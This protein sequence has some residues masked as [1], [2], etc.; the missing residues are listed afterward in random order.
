MKNYR[1][2]NTEQGYLND[3]PN[4]SNLDTYAALSKENNKIFIDQGMAKKAIIQPSKSGPADICLYDKQN[5]KLI[6]VKNDLFSVDYFPADKYAPIGIVVVPG[7]HNVYNDGSCG[8]M[9]LKEMNRNSPDDGSTS[10]QDMSWGGV[11]Y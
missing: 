8:V 1:I 3:K 4:L 7:S 6:I 10:Y 5:D 11:Q 2:Y 9:S